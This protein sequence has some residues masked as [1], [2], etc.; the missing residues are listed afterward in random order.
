MGWGIALAAVSA[1]FGGFNAYDEYHANRQIRR[2]LEKIKKYLL[3]IDQK[4]SVVM[5]QNRQILNLLDKLPEQFRE[6]IWEIQ[7]E[8]MLAERYSSVR[9]TR[10][11]FLLLRGG[12]RYRLRDTEWIHFSDAMTYLFEHEYRPS[13]AFALIGVA[14]IA[15]VITKERAYPLVI[16]R[17]TDK[18]DEQKEFRDDVVHELGVKLSALKA[19]LDNTK[20]IASHNLNDDLQD[21]SQLEINKVSDRTRRENYSERVCHWETRGGRYED[22]RV[23]VCRNVGRHR[24]VADTAFHRARDKYI[25][26]LEPEINEIIQIISHIKELNGVIHSLDLYIERISQ[27]TMLLQ[28]IASL[29]TP[30]GF[31][32]EGEELDVYPMYFDFDKDGDPIDRKPLPEGA[33][34]DFDDYIDGCHGNCDSIMGLDIDDDNPSFISLKLLRCEH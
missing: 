10:D 14:E 31:L 21:I 26:A 25:K 5:G 3:G 28:N 23:R 30:E 2:D 22:R 27:K 20:Y 6:I 18:R 33:Y 1:V 4:L 15:L 7:S 9:N 17:V 13:K 24:M 12:H 29:T 34:D 8:G 11:N 32:S 16:K 19:R